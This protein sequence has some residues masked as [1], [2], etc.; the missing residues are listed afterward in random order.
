M[1]GFS[2]RSIEAISSWIADMGYECIEVERIPS[3]SLL[4]VYIDFVEK[5]AK[6]KQQLL[7]NAESVEEPHG[8]LLGLE[9][10]ARVSRRLSEIEGDK[11]DEIFP[12]GYHLEV[13]SPGIERPLR[14]LKH[15]KEFIGSAVRIALREKVDAQ[16]QASGTLL[17]ASENGEIVISTAKG[18]L[19][20]MLPQLK[21]AHLIYDW[22]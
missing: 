7:E 4:R 16:G 8:H 6:G 5:N 20:F 17:G 22:N 21:K 10:C 15:F 1:Q 13:S 12:A 3:Q 11:M 18:E 19:R 14:L 2:E 9:D